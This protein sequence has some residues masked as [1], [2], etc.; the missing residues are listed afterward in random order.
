MNDFRKK[1]LSSIHLYLADRSKPDR[2]IIISINAHKE[3]D[4]EIEREGMSNGLNGLKINISIRCY[5][6]PFRHAMLLQG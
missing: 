6:N 1:M 4:S 2:T 5:F 3:K